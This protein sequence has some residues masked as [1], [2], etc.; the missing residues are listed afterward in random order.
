MDGNSRWATR[1]G[2][3]AF[4]GHERGVAALRAA[5]VTAREWGIPAL[6]VRMLVLRPLLLMT[7]SQTWR[8]YS[9]SEAG[10]VGTLCRKYGILL[11]Q[12][13]EGSQLPW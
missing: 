4:V 11:L 12:Q 13:M 3:P 5:V 6:T 1:Q 8:N 7:L 9:C 10:V 2:L